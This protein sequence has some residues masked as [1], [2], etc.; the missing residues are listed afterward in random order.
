MKKL[1]LSQVAALALMITSLIS[2]TTCVLIAYQ[3]P[4]PESAKKLRKF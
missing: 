4:M 3:D 2:N 1:L